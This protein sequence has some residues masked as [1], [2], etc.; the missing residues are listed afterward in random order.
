MAC[1]ERGCDKPAKTRFWVRVYRA[2]LV[3][4]NLEDWTIQRLA[5][6]G[7][8]QKCAR[9]RPCDFLAVVAISGRP[10]HKYKNKNMLRA[11]S[12]VF[13]WSAAVLADDKCVGGWQTGDGYGGSGAYETYVGTYTSRE[14]CIDAVKSRNDGAN[15]ATYT[16]QA[17]GSYYVGLCFAEYFQTAVYYTSYWENCLFES[18]IGTVVSGLSAEVG[19]CLDS[20][21]FHYADGATTKF[22]Q[23]GGGSVPRVDLDPTAEYV[24]GLVQYEGCNEYLGGGIEFIVRSIATGLATRTVSF[25]GSYQSLIVR[26]EFNVEWPCRIIGF[27]TSP[28]DTYASTSETVTYVHTHC[29]LVPT[30]APTITPVPTVTFQ[31]TPLPTNGPTPRPTVPL[32]G[33]ELI[34]VGYSECPYDPDLATCDVVAC[35]E[36]CGTHSNL[37]N[38]GGDDIYRKLCGTPAPTVSPAPT[39]EATPGPTPAPIIHRGRFLRWIR[40]I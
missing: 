23:S 8:P 22:G 17:S 15:A 34:A 13:C 18:D 32:C 35:G 36:L 24:S 2:G 4:I 40:S 19:W 14:D 12:A 6:R 29:E 27:A 21:T 28:G 39:P 16:I 26:A 10:S 3:K 9:R 31:P 20:I 25:A 7:Q 38:C 11:A 33:S 37:D 30:A 5:T 1:S